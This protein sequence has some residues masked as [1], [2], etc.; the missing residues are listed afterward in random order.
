MK[1]RLTELGSNVAGIWAIS[2][3]VIYLI[4]LISKV[5]IFRDV[6]DIVGGLALS[7]FLVYPIWMLLY[8]L[9]QVGKSLIEPVINER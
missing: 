6:L 4:L 9:Y 8:A 2:A 5:L 3:I 7:L 1:T